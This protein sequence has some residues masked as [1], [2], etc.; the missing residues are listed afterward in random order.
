MN[1]S[2]GVNTAYSYDPVSRLT[3]IT[4]G[5]LGTDTFEYDA[6]GQRVKR[7]TP[8]AQALTTQAS[9]SAVDPANQLLTSGGTSYTH[10]ANG[11][12]LTAATANYTWDARNRLASLTDGGQTYQFEYDPS[13]MMISQTVGGVAQNFVL[14]DLTNVAYSSTSG[15]FLTA[16]TIDSHLAQIDLGGSPTFAL[17]DAINST[18]ATTDFSGAIASRFYYE[19]YGQTTV[20]GASYPFQ[21]TGRGPVTGNIYYYRARFH[22]VAA[23]RFLS[24]DPSRFD[25]GINLYEYV[26][27]RPIDQSDPLGLQAAPLLPRLAPFMEVYGRGTNLYGRVPPHAL[28]PAQR[29]NP[30]ARISKVTP[31]P[32]PRFCPR[33][34]PPIIPPVELPPY[35][36]LLYEIGNLINAGGQAPPLAPVVPIPSPKDIDLAKCIRE[37]R[38]T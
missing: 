4:H 19:S 5:S 6:A 17:T 25:G 20:T 34:N 38:C 21:F 8:F 13:G 3:S 37:G 35:L 10:D 12:R 23:G 33:P 15:S 2:N 30:A 26:A 7:T 27:N 14:D 29:F 32:I 22:D 36:K 9:T 18:T 24:E 11:N 31:R 28:A 16:R 1:R